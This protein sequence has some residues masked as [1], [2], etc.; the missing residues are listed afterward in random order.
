MLLN[1]VQHTREL[2]EYR[3][4]AAKSLQSCQILCDPIDG[5]PPGFP[6]P[7]ILQARTLEWVSIS[8]S[9]K[10]RIIQPQ[11]WI[12]LR[13]GKHTLPVVPNIFSTRDWFCERHFCHAPGQ[14]GDGLRMVQVCYIY[15]A[16]YFY[17]YCISST[18]DHQSLDRGGWD[19]CLRW[20]WLHLSPFPM[21]RR[22]MQWCTML[23]HVCQGSKPGSLNLQGRWNLSPWPGGSP[24]Q[25]WIPYIQTERIHMSVYI[26]ILTVLLYI[27]HRTPVTTRPETHPLQVCF[28][29][30][31][32]CGPPELLL[33]G[34]FPSLFPSSPDVV[35]SLR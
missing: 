15:G 28:V 7:E 20:K 6:V 33:P 5:S 11:M 9:T 13:W 10:Y 23:D 26:H 34:T 17:Y 32:R 35:S 14:S 29:V 19:P 1:K 30:L 3:I 18:S 4:A 16:L 31:F 24:L 25:F 8:F 12:M 22:K 21:A 2:S 27:S